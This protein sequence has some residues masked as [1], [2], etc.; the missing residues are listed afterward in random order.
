MLPSAGCC[1][2]AA[3]TARQVLLL[4]AE[5]GQARV[6]AAGG[7]PRGPARRGLGVALRIPEGAREL[8]HHAGHAPGHHA[9]EV[10]QHHRVRLGVRRAGG[11]HEQLAGGVVHRE[12]GHPR[13]PAA[14]QRAERQLVATRSAPHRGGPPAPPRGSRAACRAPPFRARARSSR[15]P[16]ARWRA[17]RPSAAGRRPP[18]RDAPCARPPLRPASGGRPSAR[19]PRG[20]SVSP[21]PAPVTPPIALAV[22]ITRPPPRATSGPSTGPGAA[23]PRSRPPG[24]AGRE[25]PASRAHRAARFPPRARWSEARTCRSPTAEQIGR[26]G[27]GALPEANRAFTVAH[28]EGLGGQGAD[29]AVLLARTSRQPAEQVAQ[30]ALARERRDRERDRTSGS[31]RTARPRGRAGSGR[32][33]RGSG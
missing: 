19:P 21:P 1:I 16:P 5:R 22:S 10:R 4:H 30:H 9:R 24:P 3:A 18:A 31:A 12:A 32:A 11:A 14:E 25:P 23:W 29:S 17:A 15:S 27:R 2:T 26:L 20:S 13:R 33:A 8:A 28:R 7:E 6:A